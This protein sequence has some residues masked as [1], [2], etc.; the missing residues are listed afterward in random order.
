MDQ[1]PPPSSNRGGEMKTSIDSL[2]E[3][4]RERGKSELSS[5]AATLGVSPNIVENWAKVLEGG[6]LIRITYEVGRMHMEPINTPQEQI[7][8]VASKAEAQKYVVRNQVDVERITL[9]KF[10]KDLE[11]VASNVSNMETIYKQKLPQIQTMSAE[12]DKI[13]IP[14]EEKIK[15]I[16]E[17]RGATDSYVLEMNKKID[18]LYA[19]V[20]FIGSGDVDK[21]A[22]AK[23]LE[24]EETIKRADAA[25]QSIRDLDETKHSFYQSLGLDID[26]RVK[27]FKMMAKKSIDDIY[28]GIRMKGSEADLILKQVREEQAE[29][30]KIL[31]EIDST[32][33]DAEVAKRALSATR[34]QFKDRSNRV[35]DEINQD[36]KVFQTKYTAI[37]SAVDEIKL[38]VK[39]ATEISDAIKKAKSDIA[40]INREINEAKTKATQ[41]SQQLDAVNAS[42]SLSPERKAKAVE[43]LTK[44]NE[45]VAQKTEMIKQS[46]AD[47]AKSAKERA[48]GK[49]GKEGKEEPGK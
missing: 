12:L 24:L 37:K 15:K 18:D 43:D 13:S 8:E 3:L 47:T 49:S 34:A 20:G 16:Q 21:A 6:K 31:S 26:T 9:D 4:L 39:D 46:I 1:S 27:E 36:D 7:E 5:V 33:K 30:R 25:R 28:A 17:I 2:L 45:D 11:Q 48:K 38:S 14:I 44:Q 35:I 23:L 22:H 10:S 19:K 42:R 40:D 41:I 29:A 32:R